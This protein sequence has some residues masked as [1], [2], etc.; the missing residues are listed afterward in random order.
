MNE[1]VEKYIMSSDL[2]MLLQRDYTFVMDALPIV[3]I[4]QMLNLMTALLQE[5]VQN[6]ET[7]EKKNFE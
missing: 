4:N 2:F 7:V 6:Q 5:K 1:L 3:K